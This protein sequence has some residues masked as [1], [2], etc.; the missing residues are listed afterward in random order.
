MAQQGTST[1]GIQLGFYSGAFANDPTHVHLL[2]VT[3]REEL[4]RL[5]EHKLLLASPGGALTDD[6]LAAL[7]R[8]PC[9]IALGPKP[10]DVVHGILSEI[11]HLDATRWVQPRYVATMVPMVALLGMG[12]RSAI[13]QDTTIPKLVET[14]LKSYGLKQGDHFEILVSNDKKS[15]E[16]DYIVQYQESDWDFIQRWLEHEG[17]FYWLKHHAKGATLVI[18]DANAD[19]TAID[20]PS[21]ISYRERNNLATGGKP[22]VW[23]F[24]VRQ[25][26]IPSR[27]VVVD[28]NYRRPADM[29]IATSAVAQ[30]GFGTRFHFGEHFKDVDLGKEIA[31][32]RA[33]RHLT[34][35][36]T[37]TGVT[38]CSRFRVGHRF[39]LENHHV[40][41]YD[42]KYLI[43][44]I[45]HRVGYGV[46]PRTEAFRETEDGHA[47]GY[48]AAFEAIPFEVP[49]RPERSTSWPRIHGFVHGHIEADSAGDYAQIDDQGRYKVKLP[50]DVGTAKGLSASRWIRM[51]QPYSGA[52]YGSHFPL[53]K[54]AEVLV[55]F[56]DG[57]P[58]RPI[59]VGSVPNPHTASPVTG[60][61]ATQSVIQTA[62]GIRVEL[63]DLQK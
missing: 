40:A 22:T 8:E 59:I 14:I 41:A 61:N 13:Y 10:G 23:D 1:Q 63:E 4:S 21:V 9:V 52:G 11:E 62:S 26:R 56:A 27:V 53:H 35:Q 33:E 57:D 42:G 17:Y 38:D 15:P 31:K 20:D 6:E 48:G 50:F 24:H 5:F 12:Q 55:S 28:Y 7:V 49:F 47:T 37:I 45:E 54:G 39:E 3:G 29:L 30:A 16:R 43:T 44:A 51:A 46:A 32:L 60:A 58:D 25:R 18:A 19:T 36:R 2:G 34:E